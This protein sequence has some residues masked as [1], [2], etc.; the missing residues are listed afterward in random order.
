MGVGT[1][2]VDMSECRVLTT[3]VRALFLSLSSAAS[4]G[5][6]LLFFVCVDLEFGGFACGGVM[7]SG[8]WR[9]WSAPMLKTRRDAWVYSLQ[10][11]VPVL[12][13]CPRAHPVE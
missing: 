2:V 8:V 13:S 6:V 1:C 9:V 12:I 10:Y 4:N 5:V 7:E 11:L 3:R